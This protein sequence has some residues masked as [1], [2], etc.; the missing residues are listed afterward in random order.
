MPSWQSH[1]LVSAATRGAGRRETMAEDWSA[2]AWSY[3]HGDVAPECVPAFPTRSAQ[4]PGWDTCLGPDGRMQYTRGGEVRDTMPEATPVGSE[5]ERVVFGC[6]MER[7]FA[8]YGYLPALWPASDRERER[9]MR[10]FRL[11]GYSDWSAVQRVE[12]LA[13]LTLG[14][15]YARAK[16]LEIRGDAPGDPMD[17]GA[18]AVAQ[19]IEWPCSQAGSENGPLEQPIGAHALYWGDAL[20]RFSV[21]D[22]AADWRFARNPERG[23]YRFLVSIPLVS[24]R[25]EVFG[26]L[27]VADTEP[28]ALFTPD[29]A[30]MLWEL[31]GMAVDALELLL[32]RFQLDQRD[33]MKRSVED[34]M[35]HFLRL[36]EDAGSSQALA[37]ESEAFEMSTRRQLSVDSLSQDAEPPHEVYEHI[38]QYTA[39]SVRAAMSLS[40]VVLFDLGNF[41]LSV[42]PARDGAHDAVVYLLPDKLD[43]RTGLNQRRIVREQRGA[44][45]R[46]SAGDGAETGGASEEQSRFPPL[47]VLGAKEELRAPASRSETLTLA[48][49]QQL[50]ELLRTAQEGVRFDQDATTVLS[51]L[52]PPEVRDVLAVPILALERQPF[53]LI[54]AYT[55]ADSLSPVLD[56]VSEVAMQH[57]RAIGYMMLNVV[58]K[59]S[60]VLADRAKSFFISNM[61][62][63]LRTP[64][65]GFLAS[66]E[67]LRDTLLD[68]MQLSF[69]DTVEACGRGLLELVNHVLDYTKLQGSAADKQRS[70]SGG[71]VDCDLTRLIQEV[72]DSSWIGQKSRHATEAATGIGGVYAPGGGFAA[73]DRV[74]MVIDIGYRA[75][76]WF[77]R[78]DSGGMRRVLMNLVGNALKFTTAGFVQV[79]L[80]GTDLGDG[81]QRVVL[82]V[83]DTGRGISR[84]F[85]DK[86]LFQPFTQ[87]NPMGTGTGL[88]LSIVK[89]IVES[90]LA[91]GTIDVYSTPGVGT[92]IRISCE[93]VEVAAKEPAA[94]AEA[95]AEGPALPMPVPAYRPTLDAGQRYTVH[96]LGFDMEEAGQ[97]ALCTSLA[98]YLEHWWHFAVEVHGR[99]WDRSRW[100]FGEPDAEVRDV[101]MVNEDT[102]QPAQLVAA[103]G[104]RRA[105]LPLV[106]VLSNLRNDAELVGMCRAYHDA[107]GLARTVFKPAGPARLETLLAFFVQYMDRVH[108]GEVRPSEDTDPFAPLPGSGAEERRRSEAV[109]HA[110][111]LGE[112][113]ASASGDVSPRSTAPHVSPRSTARRTLSPVVTRLTLNESDVSDVPSTPTSGIAPS[114]PLSAVPLDGSPQSESGARGSLPAARVL[115]VDDNEVNRRVLAAYL[116]KLHAEYVEARDGQEA[117]DAFAGS[118]AGYFTAVVMDLTMPRLD[119]FS[120]TAEIRRIEERRSVERGAETPRAVDGPATAAAPERRVPVFILTGSTSPNDERLGF[121]AGADGF[122]AKPLS[123]RAFAPLLRQ[124]HADL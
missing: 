70:F 109:A 35:R 58:L 62:H 31:A 5:D 46:V 78:C 49:V 32:D 118:P 119:G 77:V 22:A 8:R 19:I 63:E 114:T 53:C 92:G 28:R 25:G 21:P 105:P 54:C 79:S 103:R 29:E 81:R 117:V 1:T 73:L 16:I 121:G 89:S 107:G 91:N 38:Y 24:S 69:V 96:L 48:E 10:K 61:S 39:E 56:Q 108:A 110:A 101:V 50:C 102:S 30:K 9:A 88:G 26:L 97:R 86:Q 122:L 51:K 82:E 57:I 6:Y 65:H 36:E 17:C 90:S 20:E 113:G 112:V 72:C 40:G 14:M 94:E 93:L 27:T 84:E 23:P 74:E 18:S 60:L 95:G 12:R 47:Q 15:P 116:R 83:R 99:T 75:E 52:L 37:T 120:A 68:S 124:A 33:R 100:G 13:A 98:G 55:T 11:P 76:G 66:T 4:F 59:K 45:G 67:L 2:F 104:A 43:D 34:Y 111:V 80:H 87:E 115:I 44:R 3:I 71:Y 64:L 106:V 123:F 85:L 7:F 42:Q 41:S